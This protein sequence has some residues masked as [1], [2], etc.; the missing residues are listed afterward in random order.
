MIKNEY[1]KGFYLDEKIGKER[2][3][4]LEKYLRLIG[5]FDEKE[6][7]SVVD[8]IYNPEIGD[9][10]EIKD[11]DNTTFKYYNYGLDRDIRSTKRYNMNF[12][13]LMKRENS[14]IE[15]TYNFQTDKHK[16][17]LLDNLYVSQ[18]KI[19]VSED[20]DF[21]VRTGHFRSNGLDLVTESKMYKLNIDEK[22]TDY[23]LENLNY[24]VAQVKNL[25]A[26]NMENL[27][28]L[29]SSKKDIKS[30]S[31]LKDNH[32]I[33]TMAFRNQDPIYYQITDENK[34]ITVDY[35]L[36]GIIR[37]VDRVGFEE[38]KEALPLQSEKVESEVKRLL[39]SL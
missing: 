36:D 17:D 37:R 9:I 11:K 33:F 29:I 2:L 13:F 27:L 28:N 5:N 31:I 3:I 26:I 18:I 39:K 1:A 4:F 32:E 6:D 24:L 14:N 21:I 35:E 22:S 25:E 38:Y 20:T 8:S 10:Y 7:I 19:P 12:Q 30:C 15:Y 23:Y 16:T 34:T